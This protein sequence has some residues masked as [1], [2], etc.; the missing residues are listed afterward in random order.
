MTPSIFQRL[1]DSEINFEVSSFWDGGFDVGLGDAMN[2]FYEQGQVR[3]WDQVEQW[4]RSAA[5]RHYPNSDFA[6]HE[7]G[8]RWIAS[9]KAQEERQPR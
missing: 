3:T 5:L 1:Y 2:G 7:L 4:L 9:E 8:A 6:K